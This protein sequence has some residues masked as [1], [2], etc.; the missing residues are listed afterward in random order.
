MVS[1]GMTGQSSGRGTCVTP[2]TYLQSEEKDRDEVHGHLLRRMNLPSSGNT[3]CFWS[4]VARKSLN[5]VV[6]EN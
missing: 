3:R 2:N 5:R 6:E 1:H 4:G